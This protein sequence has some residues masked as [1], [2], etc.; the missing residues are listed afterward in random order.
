MRFGFNEGF[1]IK[2]FED[3]I[4][5]AIEKIDHLLALSSD[6][7]RQLKMVRPICENANYPYDYID[8]L[9]SSQEELE[10]LFKDAQILKKTLMDLPKLTGISDDKSPFTDI[11]L[12]I[13]QE[14]LMVRYKGFDMV[15]TDRVG[16]SISLKPL[17]PYSAPTSFFV[18]LTLS[19]NLATFEF[20]NSRGRKCKEPHYMN[21]DDFERC[22]KGG[23][24]V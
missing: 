21:K 10:S 18:N 2:L 8:S 20:I 4:Q 24:K 17:Y 6:E 19:S 9:K 16:Q 3:D 1:V 7:I 11:N 22:F 12:G 14:G 5:S 23:K 15:V 13:F